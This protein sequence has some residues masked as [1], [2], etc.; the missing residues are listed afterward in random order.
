MFGDVSLILTQYTLGLLTKN[1]FLHE[2]S[3]RALYYVLLGIGRALTSFICTLAFVHVGDDVTRTIRR[4]FFDS[5][6][7]QKIEYYDEIGPG[8]LATRMSVDMNQIQNALS[9][10]IAV[11]ITDVSGFVV[12]V[13]KFLHFLPAP[14]EWQKLP[15]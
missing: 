10:N 9:Q 5:L 8:E 4:S 14:A 3:T 15:L 11:L 13:P 2:M 1:H 7:R 12:S 6:L